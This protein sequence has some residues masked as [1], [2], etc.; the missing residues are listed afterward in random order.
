MNFFPR[1]RHTK[2]YATAC[3]DALDARYFLNAK[4]V[5]G[6]NLQLDYQPLKIPILTKLFWI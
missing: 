5:Q 2:R 6:M 3:F 4:S 1:A